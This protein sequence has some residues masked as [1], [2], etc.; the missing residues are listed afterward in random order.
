M[1]PTR[2]RPFNEVNREAAPPIYRRLAPILHHLLTPVCRR[3]WD[4]FPSLPKTGPAIIVSN[5]LSSFDAVTVVD[6][7]LYHGRMAYFLAKGGL[8]KLPVLGRLLRAID[9]VPVYRGTH[10]AGGALVE[11]ARRLEAGKVVVIFTE[12]T[13]CRDPELWP[14]AVKT[15]AA[16]LA[17]ATGAPVIPIGHWG[18]STI[19][20]DNAGPQREP[21]PIPRPWVRFRSGPA[22]DLSAFG[23][24]PSDR[25]MVRAAATT[26]LGAIVAQVERARGETAPALRWNPKTKGYVPLDEAVW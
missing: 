2:T 23:R 4:D 13:T 7:V 12:G 24:D 22:V 11:A 25:A 19:C 26:I 14:F 5:H 16:R 8:F 18:T 3:D 20:P 15:G 6:Y 1:K 17:I 10:L 9:Q 21:H